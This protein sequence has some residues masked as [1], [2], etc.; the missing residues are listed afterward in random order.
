MIKNVL[1]EI[2]GLHNRREIFLTRWAKQAFR[3]LVLSNLIV[4]LGAFSFAY[5]A[6]MLAGR[7][8][9]FAFPLLTFLYLYAMHVFN[10]FLDKGASAYNDP[11]RATFLQTH[12]DLLNIT[13]ITAIIMALALSYMIGVLTFIALTALS[14]LGI[15][16]S[17]PL[18]PE[19]FRHNMGSR[20]HC[21][22]DARDR[23][24][25]AFASNHNRLSRIFMELC[26]GNFLQSLPGTGRSDGGS[27]NAA[28]YIR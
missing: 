16:Y 14:L 1:K 22:A 21:L 8:P 25:K 26:Q 5:A 11:D 28:D 15:I 27:R 17:I 4:A 24:R 9:N 10:H 7:E 13:G 2:E 18:V 20:Y 3:F 6:S 23:R 19:Q 12:K